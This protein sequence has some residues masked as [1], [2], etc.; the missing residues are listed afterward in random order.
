MELAGGDFGSGFASGAVSSLVSSGVQGLGMSGGGQ[1]NK[2]GQ[3]DWYN[4]ATIAAGGLSGGISSTIAGG[5]FWAGA[6][7]GLITSGL[8]HVAHK[9]AFEIGKDP[10]IPDLTKEFKQQL[11]ETRKFF[12]NL[13]NLYDLSGL[14][15][16]PVTNEAMRMEAFRTLTTDGGKFD[17]KNLDD[18]NGTFGYRTLKNGAYYKGE[19]FRFDDFGNYNFGVAANAYGYSLKFVQFAAGINQMTKFFEWQHWTTFF[20]DPRD[21]KM[22]ERGYNLEWK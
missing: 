22:I 11:R 13:K 6:R 18:G 21:Y 12:K 4:A 5:N 9:I 10:D 19:L 17:L 15:L 3:S 16:G 8:N 1:S 2:F 20:D 7:Q 14:A